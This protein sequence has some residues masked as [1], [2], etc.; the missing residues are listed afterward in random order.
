MSLRPSSRA[1]LGALA[2]CAAAAAAGLG[3]RASAA[4]AAG[5]ATAVRAGR[6]EAGDV[7]RAVI[8][9]GDSAAATMSFAPAGAP[10]VGG[11]SEVRRALDA[12]A[13]GT[14][15]DEM[16]RSRD[17][18]LARWPDRVERPLQVWIRPSS[19]IRGWRPGFAARAREAFDEWG[20]SGVPLRF[21]F[22]ADSALADVH[23]TW[24]DRF[25]EPISGKT[26]WARDDRWWIVSA[27]VV[28]ALHHRDGSPLDESAMRAIAL[29]EIGHLVGL[30]HTVDT[31][32][33]MAPRVR[34]RALS[35]ADRATARLLYSVPPGRV[36]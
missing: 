1:A 28:L 27:D 13:R 36:R 11:R 22:V 16:L 26:L 24:V 7:A 34:V 10:G 12:G 9:D 31:G 15:I 32:N 2:F 3:A 5:V 23:L 35:A 14:Y 20:R 19:A 25:D 30:D 18:S 6:T 29:H 21:A 8:G 17:S 4:P 33:I